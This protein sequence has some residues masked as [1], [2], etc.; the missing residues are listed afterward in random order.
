MMKISSL[1]KI[2][3]LLLL[4]ILSWRCSTKNDKRNIRN[5]Y[6]PV[7]NFMDGKVYE[8]KAVNDSLAPFYWYFRTTV[9]NGDTI[10]NN[11]TYQKKG[12]SISGPALGFILFL[13]VETSATP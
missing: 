4:L 3:A 9:T 13:N 6:Y 8:Y 7:A 2:S 1:L 11:I 5:Y 10:L 12:E